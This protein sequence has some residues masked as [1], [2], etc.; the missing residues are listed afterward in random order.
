L[1]RERV[2]KIEQLPLHPYLQAVLSFSLAA[3]G[4][5]LQSFE[6]TRD[7]HDERASLEFFQ[8]IGSAS[9]SYGRVL[10]TA[11]WAYVARVVELTWRD[12][13]DEVIELVLAALPPTGEPEQRIVEYGPLSG[14]GDPHEDAHLHFQRT[15]LA[16]MRGAALG[17][18][19]SDDAP[20]EGLELWLVAWAD[21]WSTFGRLQGQY[22]PERPLADRLAS[23]P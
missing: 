14:T 15:V 13:Y 19:P 17:R 20:I 3:G 4:D 6:R 12:R 1:L 5:A 10:A 18:S 21:G 8:A 23:R 16:A 2:E 9:E 11:G 22:F 7:L